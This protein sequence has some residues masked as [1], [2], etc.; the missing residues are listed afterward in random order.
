MRQKADVNEKMKALLGV[1]RTGRQ[2]L[3]DK[4]RKDSNDGVCARTCACRP[5]QRDAQLSTVGPQQLG[6]PYCL[7]ITCILPTA[8]D[9]QTNGPHHPS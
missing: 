7:S 2:K 8:P 3:L 6:T 9:L 5:M 1:A 4:R